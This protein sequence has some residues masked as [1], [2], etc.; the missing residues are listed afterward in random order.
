ML[1]CLFLGG[2]MRITGW[3]CSLLMCVGLSAQ[4]AEECVSQ[5]EMREIAQ[6]FTQFGELAEKSEYCID[7]S[8]TGRLVSGIMFMRKTKFAPQMPASADELFSGKFSGNWYDYFIGRITDFEVQTSCDKGVVAFVYF[9]GTSMYV[10]PIALTPNFTSLDLASVFMHEARHIDGFPHVTCTRGPRQGLSGACDS[11]MSE[12][13]SYAVS[14]ETFAQ[15]G[16]YATDLHPAL[17]A[18]AK[19]SAVVYADEAFEVPVRIDR[20][21]RLLVLTSDRKFHVL[22][23][24]TGD[25]TDELGQSPALGKIAMRAHYMILYPEDRNLNSRYLFA[26]NEGEIKQEGGE[27]AAEYN[28]LAASERAN[29]VDVHIAAQWNVKVLR[30]KL[31]FACDPRS[32]TKVDV[33]T[34]GEVPASIVYP[35]GY[36]RA[37]DT[38]QIVMESGKVFDF[39]CASRRAFLRPSTIALDQPYKRIHKV[40]TDVIGLN[41][42]GKLFRISGPTSTPIAAQLSA[43]NEIAPNQTYK[44]FEN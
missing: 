43:V 31:T 10:C 36:D 3:I 1:R 44:F 14:V 24:T 20:E 42:E 40:G 33:P 35:N 32:P 21:N 8:P 23:T 25:V 5:A 9:F 15:I 18:Y 29:W 27:M 16:K 11:L 38:A 7:E 2:N 41:K 28:T 4:A 17:R 30:D 19:S 6:H 13:G 26:N 22:N 34:N 39:G 37:A 12:G